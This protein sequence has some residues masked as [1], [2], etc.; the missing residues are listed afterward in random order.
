M[1]TSTLAEFKQEFLR[2]YN[3]N[4]RPHAHHTRCTDRET[5]YIIDLWNRRYPQYQD[6]SYV[7]NSWGL[8]SPE[9]HEG[10][11]DIAFYGCSETW[12]QGMPEPARYCD[13][14]VTA[15]N[16][17]TYTVWA[18]PGMGIGEIAH[19]YMASQKYQPSRRVCMLLPDVYRRVIPYEVV[20]PHKSQPPE[21]N[22]YM[23]TV[24][25]TEPQDPR[26]VGDVKQM[27][28]QCQVYIEQSNLMFADQ[29]RND[30]LLISAG[31]HLRN[32]Q[33]YLAS[34]YESVHN[35]LIELS[36][37]TKLYTVPEFVPRR[38]VARD[39][40]HMGMDSHTAWAESF[41]RAIKEHN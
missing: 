31:A 41:V 30:I 16:L 23:M 4:L 36:A 10:A 21:I 13:Q 3:Y 28:Q 38:D 32:Q 7:S 25:A 35:D 5:D 14:I 19:V 29:F 15:M 40:L 26:F 17:N 39:G 11:I 20:K 9:V 12:G 1:G 27:S 8:R 34:W 37:R 18:V 2:R 33:L 22:Y 6:W 24:S